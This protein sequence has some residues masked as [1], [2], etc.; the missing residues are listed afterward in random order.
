[1][2]RASRVAVLLAVLLWPPTAAAQAPLIVEDI[3]VHGNHSTPDDEVLRIAAI[4]VGTRL[5]P[6]VV[7]AAR[8]RL[9]SSGR[10][11]SV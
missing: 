8:E 1:M 3:R 7:E 10:F 11:Q 5:E 6:G 2:S 4:T 9:R